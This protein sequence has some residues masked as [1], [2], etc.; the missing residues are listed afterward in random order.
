MIA[1]R[2]PIIRVKAKRGYKLSGMGLDTGVNAMAEDTMGGV[3]KAN[4]PS[5]ISRFAVAHM[6][7]F[8]EDGEAAYEI[9]HASIFKFEIV[10]LSSVVFLILLS[11][12]TTYIIHRYHLIYLPESIMSIFYGLVVRIYCSFYHLYLLI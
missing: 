8:V 9:V 6:D 5:L 10:V 11:L 7:Q 2:P 12:L 1:T 3:A 4:H